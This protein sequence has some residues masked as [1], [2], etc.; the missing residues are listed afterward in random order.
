M[1]EYKSDG[2]ET[3]LV[4]KGLRFDTVDSLG[5]DL[6]TEHTLPHHL[7]PSSV[8]LKPMNVYKDE[9][10]VKNALWET[11]ALGRMTEMAPRLVSYLKSIPWFAGSTAT[12]ATEN[13]ICSRFHRCFD[14]FQL[15]HRNFE[16]AGKR[17]KTYFTE[18]TETFTIP[19]ERTWDPP[20]IREFLMLLAN[21]DRRR[22]M[23]TKLG[24]VGSAPRIS[25]RKD[26]IC[27]L[28]RL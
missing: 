23:T 11:I 2:D 8:N 18:Q 14:S 16:I 9:E 6:P 1:H 4:C 5:C 13:S 3:H 25:Q 24:Y 26:V 20:I 7:I 27:V 21:L 10:S 12:T 19:F 22:L 28:Q 17:F 15:C